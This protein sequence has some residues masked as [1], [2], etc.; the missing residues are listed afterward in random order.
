MT[1]RADPT[2]VQAFLTWLE[3][4]AGANL[5]TAHRFENIADEIKSGEWLRFIRAVPEPVE[6]PE[7]TRRRTC[8]STR[9]RAGAS[10]A[11]WCAGPE[12]ERP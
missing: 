6:L 12:S 5:R 8:C 4:S 10:H 11:Y 7:L 1:W 3:C 2:T 9:A